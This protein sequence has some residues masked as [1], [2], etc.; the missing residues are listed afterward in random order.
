MSS[1]LNRLIVIKPTNKGILSLTDIVIT[2]RWQQLL[3]LIC[4][5]V[6]RGYK[7]YKK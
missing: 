6:D 5:N 1:N 2:L 3:K 4:N 7:C